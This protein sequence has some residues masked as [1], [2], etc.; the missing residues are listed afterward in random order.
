M[1]QPE[2]TAPLIPSEVSFSY[3]QDADCC[4]SRW[5]ELIIATQDGG[6]GPYLVI[7][8]ERWAIDP[9]G[10]DA[11]AAELRRVIGLVEGAAVHEPDC[12]RTAAE[13]HP[14]DVSAFPSSVGTP[15]H[16]AKVAA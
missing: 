10:I 6:G 16:S 1:K 8:T 7:K 15:T 12:A 5:Q 4:D 11:F 3:E 13:R 9:E 14:H 2:A